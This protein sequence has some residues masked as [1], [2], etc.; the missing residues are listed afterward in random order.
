M[1]KQIAAAAVLAL[2]ATLAFAAPHGGRDRA[3]GKWGHGEHQRRDF[4][5]MF[6]DKLILTA[7]QRQQI[8]DIQKS[9]R[10]TNAALF[11]TARQTMEEARAARKS[12]DTA[13][14]DA[15]KP[16]LDGQREQMK[17]IRQAERAKIEGVLT[18]EQRAKLTS[19][20]AEMEANRG[21]RG[22]HKEKF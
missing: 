21:Q 1:K 17:A 6:G 8:A 10:E 13:K 19:L 15:L 16:T 7:D 14:L 22:D 18:A 12:N 2:S 11:D 4:V 20:K 3:D 9:T 5:S